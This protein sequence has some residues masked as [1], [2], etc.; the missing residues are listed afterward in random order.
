MQLTQR[1]GYV[2]AQWR[3]GLLDHGPCVG[4][5]G[6][7]PTRLWVV[8]GLQA[9]AQGGSTG[10]RSRA[11]RALTVGPALLFLPGNNRSG[12]CGAAVMGVQG[13]RPPEAAFQKEVLAA[14]R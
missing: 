3:V 14:C 13:P 9:W 4:L 1:A 6:C 12:H 5:G 11:G 2:G 8:P 7:E 10:T